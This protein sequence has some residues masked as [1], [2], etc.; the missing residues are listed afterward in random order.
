[1]RRISIFIAVIGAILINAMGANAQSITV[2]RVF[3]E[4]TIGPGS[5][6][7]G[8]IYHIGPNGTSST[9]LNKTYWYAQFAPSVG[10]SISDRWS[11]GVRATLQTNYSYFHAR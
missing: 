3:A 1:M 9:D 10:V 7:V 6:H 5:R 11:V 8:R 4:F 2:P